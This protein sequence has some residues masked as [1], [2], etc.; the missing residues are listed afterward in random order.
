[1]KLLFL[2]YKGNDHV[3]ML[4]VDGVLYTSGCGDQGQ[5]GRVPECFASRGGRK[6]LSMCCMGC[7]FIKKKKS[8][9]VCWP[10]TVTNVLTN[11]LAVDS[12]FPLFPYY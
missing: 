11:R 12:L 2:C 8:S 5:L 1:M 10:V 6:G 9:C 4:T 7:F 3:V